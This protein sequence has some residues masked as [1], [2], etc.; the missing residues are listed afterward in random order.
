MLERHACICGRM[1]P[2]GKKNQAK[3]HKFKHLEP[4]RGQALDS[5][6]G[7]SNPSSA[8]VVAVGARR[9]AAS[10]AAAN[11]RDF[12]Y[13]VGDL[14]RIIVFAGLLV[15]LELLMWFL[16]AHTG[17]GSKVYNLVQV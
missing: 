15:A 2:M 4:A 5:G 8:P 9:G 17:F 16:F 7:Y 11:T 3:K 14:R 12:S 13:V 1:S 6:L 10:V